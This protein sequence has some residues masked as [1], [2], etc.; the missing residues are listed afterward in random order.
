M[1]LV[2]TLS[3]QTSGETRHESSEYSWRGVDRLV[4]FYASCA[5]PRS[6]TSVPLSNYII[7]V[8]KNI[9][10]SERS[11]S[12]SLSRFLIRVEKEGGRGAAI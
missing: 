6:Y 9:A 3:D 5:F 10:E 7:D 11:L 12:L 1:E 8:I 4:A 2:G